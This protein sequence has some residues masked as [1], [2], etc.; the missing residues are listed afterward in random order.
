MWNFLPG[1]FTGW[2]G[3]G[4]NG[5]LL[6]YAWCVTSKD[7]LQTAASI[8]IVVAH[9]LRDEISDMMD[10][11]VSVLPSPVCACVRIYIYKRIYIYNPTHPESLTKSP[12]GCG[13][14]SWWDGGGGIRTFLPPVSSVSFFF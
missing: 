6:R 5:F 11:L 13:C 2:G 4:V 14:G 10:D 8:C 9:C 1:N 7:R 12:V 3:E